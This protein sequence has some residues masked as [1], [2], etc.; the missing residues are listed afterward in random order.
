MQVFTNEY[1][2][3]IK[4]LVK[5]NKE[6]FEGSKVAE[7]LGYANPQ[8]A[9]RDHCR[10]DGTIRS[11]IKT[12]YKNNG[13]KVIFRNYPKKFIDEGNLYR[14]IIRSKMPFADKFE[15]WI[16]DEVIPSIRKTGTY[17]V[18]R[19]EALLTLGKTLSQAEDG[20]QIGEFV[21]VLKSIDI[22]IGRTRLFEWF[23]ENGYFI[24]QYNKNH[25][26]QIYMEKGL[27]KVNQQLIERDD[28]VF[29][30]INTHI[31]GKGQEFFIN[32]IK[33]DFK[34]HSIKGI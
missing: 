6:Y 3:D 18:Q 5:N 20:I 30:T 33:E 27:F 29:I 14:L 17:K 25:P 7:I 19:Q 1:F 32:K 11:T 16:F 22:D 13:G 26:K 23:R 21:K 12:V 8:K 28:R 34:N 15:R 4:V 2:G 10:D 9:V 31:T 24:K